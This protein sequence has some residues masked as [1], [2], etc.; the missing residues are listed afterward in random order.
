[1]TNEKVL[2]PAEVIDGIEWVR[3]LGKSDFYILNETSNNA[4]R[5]FA[6]KN[7]ANANK[8]M[9]ALIVGFEVDVVIKKNGF[10]EETAKD[11]VNRYKQLGSPDSFSYDDGKRDGIRLALIDLEIQIKGI[12][13]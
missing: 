9:K 2:L 8:L 7:E 5:K 6:D 10:T 12:N 13:A 4:I 11:L 3:S 1:M